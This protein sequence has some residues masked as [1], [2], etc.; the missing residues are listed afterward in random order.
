MLLLYTSLFSNFHPSV[1]IKVV[2]LNVNIK[3]GG[4]SRKLKYSSKDL[5]LYEKKKKIIPVPN[6]ERYGTTTQILC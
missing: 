2:A 5:L 4:A 6:I 3:S 1:Y